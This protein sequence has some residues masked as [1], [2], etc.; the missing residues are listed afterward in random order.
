M[1]AAHPDRQSLAYPV[2]YV[3]QEYHTTMISIC[4]VSLPT[5]LTRRVFF[6]LATMFFV[7]SSFCTDIL[8]TSCSSPLHFSGGG[9][10]CRLL[11]RGLRLHE[12][13]DDHSGKCELVCVSRMEMYGEGG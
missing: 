13:G 11:H 6:G 10:A 4:M 8:N 3:V 2:L 5:E 9:K 7:Q 1:N 12:K